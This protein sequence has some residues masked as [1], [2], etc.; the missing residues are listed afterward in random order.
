MRIIIALIPAT[1][2]IIWLYRAHR[3]LSTLG[4]APLRYASHWAVT[5]FFIPFLNFIRP[6]QVIREVWKGSHPSEAD[7]PTAPLLRLWWVFT[8]LAVGLG[9]AG[10]YIEQNNRLEDSGLLVA[11]YLLSAFVALLQIALVRG[12]DRWQWERGA[13]PAPAPG[14]G[15]RSVSRSFLVDVTAV[16]LVVLGSVF[17]YGQ[18]YRAANDAFELRAARLA[19]Y[20]REH[21]MP[22]A[23]VPSAS[24]PLAKPPE[25]IRL[26]AEKLSPIYNP[27]PRYPELAKVARVEGAVLLEVR[28]GTDGKVRSILVLSGNP[29][30]IQAAIEAV[31]QWRYK[32]VLLNGKPVE[33]LT[34][35]TVNFRLGS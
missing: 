3:N 5:G 26:S 31:Q 32:P 25:V 8:L 15:A 17:L 27:P 33:V 34:Q 16:S 18:M 29:L 7:P 13:R 12:I 35:V 30:L 14:R 22:H 9:A 2:L 1:L 11:G 28:V 6:Y 21:H 23:P 20:N 24:P 4:S 10:L 19:A